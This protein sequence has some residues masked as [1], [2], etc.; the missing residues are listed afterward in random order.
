MLAL[1][2]LMPMLPAAL[3]FAPVPEP[4][5][6]PTA[7]RMRH[8]AGGNNFAPGTERVKLNFWLMKDAADLP[9][10]STLAFNCFR[11]CPLG[12]EAACST[13]AGTPTCRGTLPPP[14]QPPSSPPSPPSPSPPPPNPPNPPDPEP[15]QPCADWQFMWPANSGHCWYRRDSNGE[16]QGPGD[17][18]FSSANAGVDAETGYLVLKIVKEPGGVWSCGEVFM[19][20]SLGPGD[21]TFVMQSDPSLVSD[22]TCIDLANDNSNNIVNGPQPG[23]WRL[24]VCGAER[25]EPGECYIQCYYCE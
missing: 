8:A 20:H 13:A 3:Q 5:L 21:Y 24:Y 9:A 7:N 2:C 11:F 1:P 4:L 18:L 12:Q 14:T 10:R 23:A 15:P 22:S 16:K 19:D 17:N 25:P 6:L